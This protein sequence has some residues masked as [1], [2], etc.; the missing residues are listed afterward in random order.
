[1]KTSRRRP[2]WSATLERWRR[3]RGLTLEAAGRRA[4]ATKCR[5]FAWESGRRP[6]LASAL[7]L[8]AL[9]AGDVALEG[10]GYG[11]V[12]PHLR[13]VALRRAG[14]TGLVLPGE[15]ALP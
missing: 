4:G 13:A 7:A 10:M 3:A 15:D 5:W 1:M 12:V 11:A 14:G 6:C 9:T 8:E 2:E